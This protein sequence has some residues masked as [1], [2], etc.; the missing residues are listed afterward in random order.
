MIRII[1]LLI[2]FPSVYAQQSVLDGIYVREHHPT[3][4]STPFDERKDFVEVT[5]TLIRDT[6]YIFSK[7]LKIKGFTNVNLQA[8]LNKWPV[9]KTKYPTISSRISEPKSN[10]YTSSKIEIIG[11][12]SLGYVQ[13]GTR[14][15]SVQ[16]ANFYIKNC[17]V[18]NA[19]YKEFVRYVRD[20]VIHSA[21][22]KK[23]PKKFNALFNHSKFNAQILEE[24][25]NDDDSILKIISDYL[26]IEDSLLFR[27]IRK[28]HKFQ[29]SRL[30]FKSSKIKYDYTNENGEKI[31]LNIYPDTLSWIH[32]MPFSWNEPMTQMY[33]WHPA[34]DNYPIVGITFNQAKAYLHW[35]SKKGIK[36]LDKKGIEYEIGLPTPEEWELTASIGYTKP[37]YE[38]ESPDRFAE[39][40]YFHDQNIAFDL[41]LARSKKKVVGTWTEKT[42]IVTLSDHLNPYSRTQ[43]NYVMDRTMHTSPVNWDNAKHTPGYFSMNQEVFHLGTNVSEWTDATYYDYKDFTETLSITLKGSLFPSLNIAGKHLD[44]RLSKFRDNYQLAIGGNWLDE[45]YEMVFGAPLKAIYTKTFAHPDSAYSTLGFR[46]VIRLKKEQKI[47]TSKSYYTIHRNSFFEALK[48]EGFKLID[49]S[50]GTKVWKKERMVFYREEKL[51]SK[52]KWSYEI[53]KPSLDPETCEFL[54]KEF[55]LIYKAIYPAGD[56]VA[57]YSPIP[58][59]SENVLFEFRIKY[60]DDHTLELIRW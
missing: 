56:V 30:K 1:F 47:N 10:L 37:V 60:I 7:P 34:Y 15:Y 57:F 12:P 59:L 35:L 53:Q 43:G 11:N 22:T 23:Y 44:A 50:T 38:D 39:F 17:E 42:E 2:F 13:G 58:G 3:K 20:S 48:K 29:S 8:F 16:H 51:S 6:N 25:M 26:V 9:K 5:Q 55:P 40:N 41:D 27:I 49:D 45:H 18:T 52:F 32:D 4:K 21:L 36:K 19:E 54:E 14:K 28:P 33:F 31:T 46:Y 24:L